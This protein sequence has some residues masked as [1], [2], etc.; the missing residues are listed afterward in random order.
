[1]SQTIYERLNF[2]DTESYKLLRR[3]TTEQ[4]RYIAASPGRLHHTLAHPILSS[5]SHKT[6]F[7]GSSVN[8]RALIESQVAR[9][10]NNE[11]AALTQ[12]ILV[13]HAQAYDPK[14]EDC[15]AVRKEVYYNTFC[16]V[17]KKYFQQYQNYTSHDDWPVKLKGYGFLRDAGALSKDDAFLHRARTAVEEDQTEASLP[18]LLGLV[19]EYAHEGDVATAMEL[20]NT[21]IEQQRITAERLQKL[22]QDIERV[23]KLQTTIKQAFNRLQVQH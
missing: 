6:F 10:L 17:M 20:L 11:K 13:R 9:L 3:F 14:N 12:P 8:L 21:S 5:Q 2:K 4:L 7:L 18:T 22:V 19:Q 1:M 15:K 23:T 16:R